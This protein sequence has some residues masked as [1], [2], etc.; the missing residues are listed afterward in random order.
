MLNLPVYATG[1]SI[2][3]NSFLCQVSFT[4]VFILILGVMA[5]HPQTVRTISGEKNRILSNLMSSEDKMDASLR[6]LFRNTR[7]IQRRDRET[8]LNPFGI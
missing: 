1:F 5:S 3:Q 4:T 2:N 7:Y 8:I 6:V